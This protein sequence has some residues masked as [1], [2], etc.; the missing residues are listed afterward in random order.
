MRRILFVCGENAGRSQ[1]AEAFFNRYSEQTDYKAE[2]CGTV[3]AGKIHATVI[4]AMA[5]KGIDL[6]SAHPKQFDPSTLHNYDRII[7]FGCLVKA[8]LPAEVRER[9]ED[10]YIEDPR[11]KPLEEVRKVRDEVERRVKL[12]IAELRSSA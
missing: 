11:D 5:E 4:E 2:S 3:P 1:M 12:L 6:T 7:S 10:W 9:I 8:T